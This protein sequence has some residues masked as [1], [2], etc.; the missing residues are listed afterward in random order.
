MPDV[1]LGKTYYNPKD[2]GQYERAL[3]EFM[4]NLKK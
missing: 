4:T 3:K 2:T 1:L